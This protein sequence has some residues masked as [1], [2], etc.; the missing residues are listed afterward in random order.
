MRSRTAAATPGT[1][2]T[3]VP[4]DQAP[5]ENIHSEEESLDEEALEDDIELPLETEELPDDPV[6]TGPCSL[7]LNLTSAESGQPV[8]AAVELWRLDAPGNE[9]WRR[10]D[11]LQARQ[12]VRVEG[13]A[14]D[15]LPAGRYRVFARD[16]RVNSED[17]PAF[18]VAG[19]TTV[20]TLSVP[21]PRKFHVHV[22]IYTESGHVL[23][24]AM[25]DDLGGSTSSDT[26]GAPKWRKER[27]LRNG[28]W[29]VRSISMGI[30]CGA[31][32]APAYEVVGTEAGFHLG[33]SQEDARGSRCTSSHSFES[34][35][36]TSVRL[37]LTREVQRDRSYLA[38]SVPEEPIVASIVMPDGRRASEAGADFRIYCSATLEEPGARADAWRALPIHVEARLEG[39][40]E[41][42]FTY[43]LG[44][45]LP[46]RCLRPKD[47]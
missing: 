9:H 30:G 1:L 23:L 32:R 7:T 18:A 12:D 5:T 36:R 4:L 8:Q 16:Q 3:P 39:F 26:D 20:V 28:F 10:G 38:L 37:F 19:P 31:N 17:P 2:L 11:Q 13:V 45:P 24:R 47:G 14:V 40:K 29:C 27:E 35:G 33:F 25:R 6:E 46:V 34:E 15:N 42:D 21:M 43:R 44:D 22:R 41:L